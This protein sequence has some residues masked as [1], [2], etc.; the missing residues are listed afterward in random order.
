MRG[1]E[2]VIER[3]L[4]LYPQADVFTH[5]Y[6][7]SRMSEIIRNASVNTTFI[8]K[9]P[10][11]HALYQYYLPL[12]PL[13]LEQLDLT[14]YDLV[15]SSEAGP[16]KGVI[17][18]P[19][20]L[21][22]CYCHSPM[23]YLWDQYH[24]YR[25]AANPIARLAMPLLYPQLR[26]WD[27]SSSARV[28]RYAANS[29]FIRRRI[30]KVWNRDATVIHPP[31][32]TSL[33]WQSSEI[34]R[35]Y[36][37]VGQLVPYK[38]PDLVVDAFN[39][40]GLPLKIV[41][42]GSMLKS[43]RKQARSNIEFIEGLDFDRLRDLYARARAYVITAEEDFGITPVEAM[44]SGR[45]VIAYGKSGVLDTVVPELTGLFYYRQDSDDLNSAIER[46]E[47]THGDF[48]PREATRRAADFAPEKFDAAIAR[49]ANIDGVARWN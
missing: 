2:R 3:L 22:V 43:L 14:G 41:G 34:D 4:N 30:Q 48:D 35:F 37:W 6:D 24:I 16:A 39:K 1:G 29:N 19:D 28:D 13:A 21:H 10:F 15:I 32:E 12:M 26:Q 45:P 31:I 11:S 25:N 9:L 23:R 38:R 33:F 47:Q 17:T 36:L 42:T 20:A 46:M 7:P 5:V 40:N 8:E 18:S 49:L 27:V 44:A